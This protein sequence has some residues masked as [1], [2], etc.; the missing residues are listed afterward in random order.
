ERNEPWSVDDAPD[1]YVAATLKGIVGIEL[2]LTRLVGKAKLS[3]NRSEA[4]A[5]IAWRES[6][7]PEEQKRIAD[8]DAELDRVLDGLL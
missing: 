8:A 5:A 3:Q 6:L 4:D 1:D 7:P 2:P